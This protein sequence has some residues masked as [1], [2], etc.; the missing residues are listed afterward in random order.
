M[1]S[2]VISSWSVWPG[3]FLAHVTKESLAS[4]IALNFRNV[5]DT[6]STQSTTSKPARRALKTL[7]ILP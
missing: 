7:G 1:I 5:D 4:V 3:L 2:L 6:A